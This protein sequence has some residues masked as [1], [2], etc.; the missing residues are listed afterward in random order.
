MRKKQSS[1]SR[2]GPPKTQTFIDT[3]PG[4]NISYRTTVRRVGEGATVLM[5]KPHKTTFQ[6]T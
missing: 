4:I 1:L 2:T 6:T 3:R 5:T